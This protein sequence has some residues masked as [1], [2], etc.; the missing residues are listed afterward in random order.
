MELAV[1]FLGHDTMQTIKY[2]GGK[3]RS[4]L[5]GE[6]TL[7]AGLSASHMIACVQNQYNCMR[8]AMASLVRPAPRHR[9]QG[10]GCTPFRRDLRT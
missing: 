4:I 3:I 8:L 1:N 10:L 7:G 5:Q 9:L 2:L 6:P